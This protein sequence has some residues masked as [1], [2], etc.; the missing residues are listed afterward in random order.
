MP[1]NPN[2]FERVEE[3]IE[4]LFEPGNESHSIGFRGLNPRI[5]NEHSSYCGCDI[6]HRTSLEGFD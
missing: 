3:I 4:L 1:E 5:L 6:I 2:V